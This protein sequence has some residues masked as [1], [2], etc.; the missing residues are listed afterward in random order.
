MVAGRVLNGLEDHG[1]AGVLCMLQH[2]G[3]TLV[4]IRVVPVVRLIAFVTADPAGHVQ[5]EI[6][7]ALVD[8]LLV[9]VGV[10]VRE[11]Q[12]IL[13]VVEHELV[14]DDAHART[15]GAG[16][17]TRAVRFC[18]ARLILCA[19]FDELPVERVLR[20]FQ[21]HPYLVVRKIAFQRERLVRAVR[22]RVANLEIPADCARVSKAVIL[23]D[24]RL[25]NVQKAVVFVDCAHG[26]PFA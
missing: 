16:E 22:E 4:S 15:G 18:Q 24:E 9:R 25:R 8:G 23:G 21:A 14:G 17:E 10:E 1:E 2:A 5:H 11:V 13:I 6:Q 12:R 20:G 26:V 7:V 3:D 19:V